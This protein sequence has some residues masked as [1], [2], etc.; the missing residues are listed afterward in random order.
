MG[1]ILDEAKDAENLAATEL[2]KAFE[3]GA[4]E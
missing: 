2:G 1:A 4:A 3:G